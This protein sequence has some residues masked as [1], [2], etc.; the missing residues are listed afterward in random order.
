ML[1]HILK[2]DSGSLMSRYDDD[3]DESLVETLEDC[4]NRRISGEPIAY[5]VGTQNF[6]GW[7]FIADKRALIP[8][9]ETEQLTEILIRKIR[10]R[11]LEHGKFLEIG[12]GAGIISIVL[13]KHFPDAEILATDISDEALSLAEENAKK[14]KTEVDFIESDLYE[15]VPKE[16][17]DLIV[18]NLPYVPTERLA[19]VSDQILDWEPMIAIDAGNDGLKYIIPMIEQTAEF[20]NENGI[21]ALEFWHTHGDEVSDLVEKHLPGYKTEV[22]KDLAGFDRYAIITPKS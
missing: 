8:R 18:A 19:F 2:V 15:K 6:F 5:I 1:G 10:E 13:K 7:E 9:P 11:H 17:F 21:V 4:V 14:L 3:V 12:T 22:E 16:K 20:L